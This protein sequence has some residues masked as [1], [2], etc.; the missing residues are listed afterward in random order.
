MNT[1]I[2]AKPSADSKGKGKATATNTLTVVGTYSIGKERIVK[3]IAQAL[4]SKIY[5]DSRK[6]AILRCQ[7]E[8]ELHALLT[9]NP[10]AEAQVHIVPLGHVNLDK[11]KEYSVKYKGHFK[12]VVGFR[13]TG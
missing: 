3:A 1:W 9:R 12:K 6:T 7:A 11:L 5:C 4:Q 2:T 8:P 13:P 10:P